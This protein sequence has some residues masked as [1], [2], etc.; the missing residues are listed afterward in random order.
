MYEFRNEQTGYVSLQHPSY[1]MAGYEPRIDPDQ[2]KY[3]REY[4]QQEEE[5]EQP[6]K[7][8]SHGMAYG[9]MGAAAG[10]VGGALLMHEGEKIG[11]LASFLLSLII[12]LAS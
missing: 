4:Q 5:Y 12:L 11:E 2:G 8:E 9:A 1:Y 7:K 10:L 6:Q 3:Q